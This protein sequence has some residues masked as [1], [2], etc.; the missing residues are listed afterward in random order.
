MRGPVVLIKDAF[1]YFQQHLGLFL[2]IYA[3]PMVLVFALSIAMES[4]FGGVEDA[5][6]PSGSE[7]GA[8]LAVLLVVVAV[9]IAASLALLRAVLQPTETIESAYRYALAHFFPFLYLSVLVG[10]ATMLGFIF[11][12]VP[13]VILFVWFMFAQ[14]LFVEKGMRGTDAMKASRELVRGMWWPVFGRLVAWLAASILVIGLAGMLGGVVSGGSTLIAEA[15]VNAVSLVLAPIAFS[16]LSFLY[17]DLKKL[18]GTSA[19]AEA[20]RADEHAA[21]A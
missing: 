14:F 9:S 2:G 11:L 21:A 7:V 16:Y 1:A 3:V 15:V 12:I 20:L 5:S 6:M 10:L 17:A 18:K 13:G 19:V 4:M 8:E